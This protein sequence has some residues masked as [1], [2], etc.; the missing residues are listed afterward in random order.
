ML[1]QK[2]FELAHYLKRKFLLR[3]L[4]YIFACNLSSIDKSTT[5]FIPA[6][7]LN[8]TISGRRKMYR[9]GIKKIMSQNST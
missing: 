5:Q 4:H 7:F 9:I 8:G 1:S 3:R 6:T 2:L